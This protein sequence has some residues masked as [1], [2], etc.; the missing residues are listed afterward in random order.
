MGVF[1]EGRLTD[2]WGRLTHFTSALIVMTSNLGAGSAGPFGLS[3]SAPPAYESE[4]MG[5]F[6]PEFFNRIDRVV[7]FDPLTPQTI[8]L[9]AEKELRDL[10]MREGLARFQIVLRCRERVIERLVE[11]VVDASYGAR[12]LQ[13][14]AGP[15]HGP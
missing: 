5:Y 10:Q 11:E 13:R 3:R 8:R 15:R 6:R 1:D 9:I 14:A 2:P 12:L 4:A 7:T